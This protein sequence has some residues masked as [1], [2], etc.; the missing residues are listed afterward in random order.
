MMHT[1]KIYHTDAFTNELFGGNPTVTVLEADTLSDKTMKK[2]AREMNMSETGFVLKSSLADFRLRF[3]TP[4]GDEIKFCGHA[5]VGALQ[6]LYLEQMFKNRDLTI[7]T[8]AGILQVTIDDSN[9]NN[10]KFIFDSP[11][12]DLKQ[13]NYDLREMLRNLEIN[14]DLIDLSKP[15]MLEKTNNYLYFTAKNLKALEKIEPNMQQM[16]KFANN[17]KIVIFC[18]MTNETFDPSFNIHTRGFAPLVGVPEDPFTGSMQGGLAAY[19]IENDL[20][21]KNSSCIKVEQ[22]HFIQRPGYVKLEVINQNPWK[23]KL[24]AQAF[25]VFS[26]TLSVNS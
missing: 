7:E 15:L 10:I 22:G 1:Y 5:T 2:I 26:S 23:I 16:I 19:A 4:P 6:T 11:I 13:V 12:I 8:N 21:N 20:V 9:L 24:H 18:I 25:P 14:P 3:F 17:D